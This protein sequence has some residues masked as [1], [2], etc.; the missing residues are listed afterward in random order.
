MICTD[1]KKN[2]HSTGPIMFDG[3]EIV[4]MSCQIDRIANDMGVDPLGDLRKPIFLHVIGE[5]SDAN[6]ELKKTI[7][8]SSRK[9]IYGT[10]LYHKL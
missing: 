2:I 3:D 7:S 9:V 5:S 4:C 1:C 10:I 6:E 8:D